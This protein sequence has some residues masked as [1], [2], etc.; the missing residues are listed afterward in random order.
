MERSGDAGR[1]GTGLIAYR[2]IACVVSPTGADMLDTGAACA[3]LCRATVESLCR[4][5]KAEM[6]P[7]PQKER[8]FVD[9]DSL[10]VS[11]FGARESNG[12]T[13]EESI[14]SA[15]SLQARSKKRAVAQGS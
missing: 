8:G 13:A 14:R 4:C 15:L 2:E 3:S 12:W 5:G 1:E 7:E 10:Y 9:A 6:R 11:A